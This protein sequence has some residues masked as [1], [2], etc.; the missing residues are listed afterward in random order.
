M[1]RFHTLKRLAG[2]LL[3]GAAVAG[4]GAGLAAALR[5]FRLQLA[6]ERERSREAGS[7]TTAA[8]QMRD[9]LMASASHDLK[10]PLASIRLLVHVL[11]RDAEKGQVTPEQLRERLELIEANVNKMSS[12]IREMLDV[13]RLQGGKPIQLQLADTDLVALTKRVAGNLEVDSSRHRIRV[14]ASEASLTGR[15]DAGRLE[16]LLT[17]IVNNARK[18]SPAGGEVTI[19]VSRGRRAGGDVAMVQIR[20]RGAGIAPEDLPHV[21]DWFYRGRNTGHV[22]GTG[23]GLASAKMI[24]EKH[25]GSIDIKSGLGRGTTVTITLPLGL[26]PRREDVQPGRSRLADPPLSSPGRGVT[27]EEA[28]QS[29][30]DRG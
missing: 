18:Y 2:N 5:R 30:A 25:G 26:G 29:A 8:L 1:L 7:Q 3:W 19:G 23:V 17:N 21:F 28:A 14:E 4:L 16:R 22:S 15:W 12:L 6:I 27:H 24:V 11:K 13:A 10:T 20:D 9:H